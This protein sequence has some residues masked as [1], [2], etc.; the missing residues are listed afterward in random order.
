MSRA[1]SFSCK[2]VNGQSIHYSC[3]FWLV[4]MVLNSSFNMNLAVEKVRLFYKNSLNLRV[5]LF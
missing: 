4:L 3:L 1:I 5:C 2:D